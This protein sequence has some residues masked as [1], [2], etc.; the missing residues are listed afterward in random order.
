MSE[1]PAYVTSPPSVRAVDFG[2]VLVLVDY[3]T[4]AVQ[5]LLPDAAAQWTRAARAGTSHPIGPPTLQRLL[6]AGLL[7]PAP[8]A[9]PWPLPVPAARARAAS[10]EFVAGNARPPRPPARLRLQAAAALS[11]VFALKHKATPAVVLRRIT[12]ALTAATAIGLPAAPDEQAHAAVLAVRHVGWGAPGRT[13]CLEESA[14]ATLL[15]AWQRTSVTWCHGIA[16]DPVRL[17]AWVQTASGTPVAE[18]PATLAYTPVL[19]IGGTHHHHT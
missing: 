14:A 10:A 18:P 4:S 19:T 1:H 13:A 17:H 11:A 16:P 6:A 5:C 15:L 8:A 3:R 9:A 12:T 2:H 7:V